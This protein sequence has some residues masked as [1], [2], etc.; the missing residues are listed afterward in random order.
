[1]RPESAH[2]FDVPMKSGAFSVFVTTCKGR[3]RLTV[4]RQLQQPASA[5]IEPRPCCLAS[6]T[7]VFFPCASATWPSPKAAE[8][9]GGAP[10]QAVH[11]RQK[12]QAP[13]GHLHCKLLSRSILRPRKFVLS[14]AAGLLT[15]GLRF[16]LLTRESH[17]EESITPW[18]AFFC[19]HALNR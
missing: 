15:Q 10:N 4:H 7:F 14:S 13:A 6:S 12:R 9:A 5:P 11:C 18:H 16:C 8:R 19:L 2:N 3:A 17:V 1:M